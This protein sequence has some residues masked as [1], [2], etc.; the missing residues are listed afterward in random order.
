MSQKSRVASPPNVGVVLAAGGAGARIGGPTPKQFLEIGGVPMLLRAIRPF[1]RHPSVGAIVVAVPTAVAAAPPK[2]LDQEC[3]DRLRLVA[4]GD[5]RLDSVRN[6]VHA[7]PPEP[8]VIL[9]HDA[10]RPFV[11]RETID[12]VIEQVSAG[13]NAIAAVPVTDTLKRTN[14][15][16][17]VR[18]TVDRADLWRAQTPQGF[19]RA[20]LEVAY[21]W[22]DRNPSD[23]SVTDEATLVEL[24]GFSVTLVPDS[25]A[26]I[27]VTTPDDFD[28]ADALSRS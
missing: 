26:N 8:P 21:E 18:E 15:S 12:R 6:A 4:G 23:A 14:S 5:T 25:T 20:Q 9:V 11:S 27:K 13:K 24:A 28:V 17:A 19:V 16:L 10:A 7:L 3:G 22:F 1:A 2:W